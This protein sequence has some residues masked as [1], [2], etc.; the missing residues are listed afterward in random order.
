MYFRRTLRLPYVESDVNKDVVGDDSETS[1]GRPTP[2]CNRKKRIELEPVV[3]EGCGGG[4]FNFLSRNNVF[5]LL[6]GFGS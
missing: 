3:E 4:D 1:C 5:T 6:R 2:D